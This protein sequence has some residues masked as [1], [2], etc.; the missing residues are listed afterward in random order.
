MRLLKVGE[1]RHHTPFTTV[2]AVLFA[3]IAFSHLLRLLL[4]W[5]VTVNGMVIPKWTSGLGLL[6]TASL[7][8]T[9]WREARK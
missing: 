5:E 4:V 8:L 1:R 6:I 2:S 9:L 3:L 7:A